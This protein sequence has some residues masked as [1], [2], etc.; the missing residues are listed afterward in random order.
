MDCGI[1]I[2]SLFLGKWFIK[3]VSIYLNIVTLLWFSLWSTSVLQWLLQ[4][5]G[6]NRTRYQR[7]WERNRVSPSAAKLLVGVGVTW[8]TG[9]RRERVNPLLGFYTLILMT[10]LSV[11][12]PLILRVQI[13]LLGGSLTPV[14]WRSSQ[15]KCPILPPTTVPAG[16]RQPTVRTDPHSLYKASVV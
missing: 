16:T 6:Y 8:S 9:T 7:L 4:D 10:I 1:I 5:S 2:F 11:V 12:I 13:S 15:L 3:P 14:S